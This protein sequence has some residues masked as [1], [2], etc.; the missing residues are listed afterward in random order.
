MGNSKNKSRSDDA[1]I[2]V[3][4]ESQSPSFNSDNPMIGVI[5]IN[6]KAVVPA[7]CIQVTL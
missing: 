7:Y 4:F 2:K 1:E 6:S 3:I 5:T